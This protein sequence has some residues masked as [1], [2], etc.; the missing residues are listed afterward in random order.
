MKNVPFHHGHILLSL[1]L[2]LLDDNKCG[3]SN[4]G[5]IHVFLHV[6]KTARKQNGA[7][8]H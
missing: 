1:N 2:N 4:L 3:F 6:R 7:A 5:I 8:T